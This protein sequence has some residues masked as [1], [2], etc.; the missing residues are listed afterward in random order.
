MELTKITKK[1][2]P[3]GRVLIPVKMRE[4]LNIE[5]SKTEVEIAVEGERIILKKT[6]KSC[7]FCNTKEELIP[8][9]GKSICV[10][11]LEEIMKYK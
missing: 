11:C 7:I 3:L 6:E 9:R 1:I 2:D 4:E 8:Y 10:N 5:A